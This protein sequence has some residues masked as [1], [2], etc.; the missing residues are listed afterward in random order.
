MNCTRTLRL[1]MGDAKQPI[2]LLDPD[3]LRVDEHAAVIFAICAAVAGSAV[4]LGLQTQDDWYRVITG[5]IATIIGIAGA[6]ASPDIA[7]NNV[8]KKRLGHHEYVRSRKASVHLA[9]IALFAVGGG[10]YFFALL[11]SVGGSEYASGWAGAAG[12]SLVL[13]I[14]GI[15]YPEDTPKGEIGLT[16]SA[17]LWRNPLRYAKRRYRRRLTRRTIG[18]P[19]PQNLAGARTGQVASPRPDRAAR[20]RRADRRARAPWPT[21]VGDPRR[22]T[23]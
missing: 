13:I 15:A 17:L 20:G 22:C 4:A 18:P 7:V 6:A 8:V 21:R 5:V 1:D 19:W 3:L 16:A 11:R 9:K 23:G 2:D 12:V 10:S 14:F